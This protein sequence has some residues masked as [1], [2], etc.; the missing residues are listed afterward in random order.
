MSLKTGPR[1]AK[2]VGKK[3][4]FSIEKIVRLANF[5]YNLEIQ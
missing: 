5:Y 3:Q 2:I 1:M 4:I